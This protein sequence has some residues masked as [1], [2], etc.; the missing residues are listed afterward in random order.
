MGW[1][2][3]YRKELKETLRD[4]RTLIIMIVV[5]VLLYPVLLVASEQLA[6]FGQRQLEE[7]AV[8][9][10][11]G[12]GLEDVSEFVSP[13][14]DA[15]A[16]P[17]GDPV[18]G[19][20][21]GTV[22]VSV[23]ERSSEAGPEILVLYDAASDRSQRGRAVA[24]A[25]LDQWSDTVVAQ[26]LEAQGVEVSVL[27]P[28]ARAD[29][30]VAR[31]AEVGGY[32]LGRF[33]PMLLVMITLLGCSYPA[34]DMAAGEKERGTLEPLL[35]PP[36]PPGQIVT[37]KF[38]AVATIG[39]SAA[40]LNL[41]SM[42]L[43]F[44]TG[45]FQFGGAIAAD[46]QLPWNVV[47][48]I[49]LTLVPLA[50]LF[51]SLFLGIAVR[52]TSFREA[53][54]AL[55]PVYMLVMLPAL[56]PLFPGIDLTPFLSMVPV[57]GVALLFREAM[58]GGA[59]IGVGVLALGSTMAW[60][61]L[62]LTFAAASFGKEQILFGVPHQEA[63]A[64]AG[65]TRRLAPNR[66]EALAFLVT[67]AILFFYIGFRLQAKYGE[68]GLFW[69][70]WGLLLGTTLAFLVLRRIQ[71]TSAL[72]LRLPS[73]THAISGVSLMMGT[74]VVA[75][76]L[77]W[78]QSFVFEIPEEFLRGMDQML[79]RP[80]GPRLLWL[81]FLIAVTPAVCEE[82]VFRGVVLSGTSR[83]WSTAKIILFNAVVFGVFHVSYESAVRFLPT[84]LLGFSLA[85]VV[86]RS[87]SLLLSGFLHF[88]NNGTIVS[89]ASRPEWLG[90]VAS[91]EGAPPLW[92][93]PFA[94]LCLTMGVRG[95]R[96]SP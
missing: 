78:L 52:A 65:G 41:G 38:L 3:V 9:I 73:V 77:A 96:R 80:D 8:R 29:S 10:G 13:Y 20:R 86:V 33:L 19:V 5:P 25:L 71:P 90:S 87:G 31:P 70:E 24:G 67:V 59:G 84:A 27:T 22:D 23:L 58:G 43:T 4:R 85:Y 46:F 81:V 66:G 44:Q 30:S 51:S 42:L 39:V 93:F 49:V 32:A 14:D 82:A 2:S 91:A 54:N 62:A 34:I 15:V 1:W 61:G 95:L 55:T 16:V 18:Q 79:S 50:V 40:L 64:Q 36:I 60:A 12:P 17:V 72:S 88:L 26:T 35:M 45:L 56:L 7:T 21:D 63:P 53:Q 76:T 28:F 57:A 48:L 89:I 75:W 69:T 37:G 47:G 74:F 11:V 94:A 92:L 6:L 83:G 68:W